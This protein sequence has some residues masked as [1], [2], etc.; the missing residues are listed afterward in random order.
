MIALAIS[1]TEYLEA[2]SEGNLEN[3]STIL[4]L[5]EAKRS[6]GIDSKTFRGRYR[7]FYRIFPVIQEISRKNV[8]LCVC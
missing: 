7:F 5:S 8:G 3:K 4:S 6:I 2:L 1:F